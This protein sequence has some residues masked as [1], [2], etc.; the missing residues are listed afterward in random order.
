[1]IQQDY[2]D[3]DKGGREGTV[4]IGRGNGKY[5]ESE[6]FWLDEVDG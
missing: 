3:M 5:L 6:D 2:A 1:M 4:R